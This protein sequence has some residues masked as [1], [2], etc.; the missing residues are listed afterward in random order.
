[1]V[2]ISRWLK[3]L[4][5]TST[6]NLNGQLKQSTEKIKALKVKEKYLSLCSLFVVCLFVCNSVETNNN[7]NNNHPRLLFKEIRTL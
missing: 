6:A 2:H 3:A 1:M 5:N 4:I 7:N